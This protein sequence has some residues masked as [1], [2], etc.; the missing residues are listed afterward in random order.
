MIAHI[1]HQQPQNS[2]EILWLLEGS[3]LG[4]YARLYMHIPSTDSW[5]E[6][7]NSDLPQ[8]LHKAGAARLRTGELM[9]VEGKNNLEKH[10]VAKNVFMGTICY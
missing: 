2:M 10:P 3:L 1:L 7:V 6:I 9:V 8:G 4:N 5:D